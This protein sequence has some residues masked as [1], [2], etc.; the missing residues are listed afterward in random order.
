MEII[1]DMTQFEQKKIQIRQPAIAHPDEERL[2]QEV[3]RFAQLI[4]QEPEP[5]ISRVQEIKEE[6]RLGIYPTKEIID[7]TAARL[8][9]RLMRPE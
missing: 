7:E 3:R 1:V 9:L 5:N 2:W 8:T 6:I 4:P